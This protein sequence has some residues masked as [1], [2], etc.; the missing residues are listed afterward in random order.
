M[1]FIPVLESKLKKP[2]APRIFDEDDK[3]NILSFYD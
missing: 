1:Y 3:N 2:E